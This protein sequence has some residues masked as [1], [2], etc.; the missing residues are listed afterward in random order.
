MTQETPKQEIPPCGLEEHKYQ[1]DRKDYW[2]KMSQ[3]KSQTSPAA[4]FY[5]KRL[6][7]IYQFLIPPNQRGVELGCGHGDL[8]MSLK[9]SRGL[10]LDF[11]QKTV[12]AA[13]SQY[14]KLDFLVADAHDLGNIHEKFDFIILSDLVNELWDLE[15]VFKQL[16]KLCFPHTRLILNF[17]SRVWEPALLMAEK[18]G[19]KK[20][21]LRQNWLSANDI[22]NLLYLADFE[23]MRHWQEILWPFPLR[24]I[25]ALFNRYLVKIWPFN[26]LGL[27]NFM[28]ARPRDGSPE[29]ENASVS[30]VI[31]A[32]NE[33]GNIPAIFDRTPAMGSHTEFIFVEGHSKDNTYETIQKEMTAHP[34]QK[35]KLLKQTGKGK[36]DAVRLGFQHAEGDV[37]MILDADLTVP[38]EDLPRFYEAIVSGKS[39]FA[40]GVRLVYPM[41]KNAMRFFNFLGNKFFS[42]AFTWLLGQN[43]KDTL[44]GTKVLWKDQYRR[45]AENRSYFGDFDPFGDFDLLFGAAKLNLKIVEIPIH[46]RERVYGTTNIE[47]WKHGVLLLKMTVMAARKI[48]FV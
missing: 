26:W 29:R 6:Q 41:E 14:P 12:A 2:E 4:R 21:S 30:I 10:G 5:R 23:T 20:A 39:E 22:S 47:R 9:P 18:F 8:L 7:E 13:K 31:P 37:L 1:E 17:Y 46:Y 32:R 3:D 11:S 35:S 25:D 43:I 24:G 36:G 48:K 28:I 33:A 42:L 34:N 15:K 16:K 40:N 38:P 45:I 27:T 19:L 44:C